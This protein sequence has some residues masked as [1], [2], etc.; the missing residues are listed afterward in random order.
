MAN[1]RKLGKYTLHETPPDSNDL[2]NRSVFYYARTK[3]NVH[4]G[5][6]VHHGEHCFFDTNCPYTHTVKKIYAN[7]TETIIYLELERMKKPKQIDFVIINLLEK[8]GN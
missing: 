2:F 5:D 8:N 3:T 7:L 1:K 6:F 4:I